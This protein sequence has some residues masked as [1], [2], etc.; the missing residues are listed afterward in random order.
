MSAPVGA[1]Y[2]ATLGHDNSRNKKV[3]IHKRFWLSALVF[4]A[5]PGEQT[6]AQG[7]IATRRAPRRGFLFSPGGE[8]LSVWFPFDENGNVYYNNNKVGQVILN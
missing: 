6:S 1:A 5:L 7:R 2:C 4:F 8:R 3:D